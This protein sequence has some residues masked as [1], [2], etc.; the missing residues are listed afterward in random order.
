M[1]NTFLLWLHI[2]GITTWF[3]GSFACAWL[4]VR[5]DASVVKVVRRTTNELI[6]PAVGVA[7]AAGIAR[8]ILLWPSYARQGSMHTKLLI[9]LAAAAL[10]G[11]L[12]GKLRR[13][14]AAAD[15]SGFPKVQGHAKFHL[16]AMMLLAT[17]AAFLAVFR[18]F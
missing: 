17:G 15:P 9:G 16:V 18:P 4:L 7:L 11:V 10:T 13:F 2:L 6:H 1:Q 5:G 12:A 3:G 14:E 8:L